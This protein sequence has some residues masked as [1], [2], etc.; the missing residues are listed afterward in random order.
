MLIQMQKINEKDIDN[1]ILKN[2]F[3][4][5]EAQYIKTILQQ[6]IYGEINF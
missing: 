3:I 2:H 1:L 4:Q 5:K 6:E